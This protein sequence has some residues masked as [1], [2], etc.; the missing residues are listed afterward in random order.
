MNDEAH[1]TMLGLFSIGLNKKGIG[2][3]RSKLPAPEHEVFIQRVKTLQPKLQALLNLPNLI[4]PYTPFIANYMREVLF[5]YHL[6]IDNVVHH[7]LDNNLSQVEFVPVYTNRH[8]VFKYDSNFVLINDHE[9]DELKQ[10]FNTFYVLLKD[11]KVKIIRVRNGIKHSTSYV[12][13][14]KANSV[15]SCLHSVHQLLDPRNYY[16]YVDNADYV[17]SLVGEYR[18]YTLSK[19]GFTTMMSWVL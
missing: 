2:K 14:K 3:I 9:L 17:K 1:L 7:Y 5:Y 4:D 15:F 16:L 12:V 6:S 19:F 11:D 10:K 8:S 18:F 13:D